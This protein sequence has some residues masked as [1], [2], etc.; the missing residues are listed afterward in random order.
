MSVYDKV[1]LAIVCDNQNKIQSLNLKK[2]Y[3]SLRTL[4]KTPT[5]NIPNCNNEY[6]RR[7]WTYSLPHIL[8]S[9]PKTLINNVRDANPKQVRSLLKR[10][11][12]YD[13]YKKEG[14]VRADNSHPE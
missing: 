2:R 4:P 6:G 5:F 1:K 10:Y 13:R 12:I 7:I 8:N 3:G 14:D 11:Y 9:L